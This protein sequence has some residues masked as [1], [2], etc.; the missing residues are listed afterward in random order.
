LSPDIWSGKSPPTVIGIDVACTKISVDLQNL[1]RSTADATIQR[2]L[3][4]LVDLTI[5]DCAF[6]AFI[7]EDAKFGQVQ[8]ARRGITHCQP[9]A[10]SGEPLADY[11]WLGSR[12]EHLRLSEL[13]DTGKPTPAQ[14]IEGRRFAALQMGS[15]LLVAFRIQDQPAGLLGLARAM[16]QGAWDVN[17]QLL[18]KLVGASLATGLDRLRMERR[19]V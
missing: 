9:D 5:S 2:N 6:L 17:L 11:P 18:L 12:L 3:Q 14:T 15:L 8:V 13:R 16:P 4:H 1:S 19:L 10:L 7:T